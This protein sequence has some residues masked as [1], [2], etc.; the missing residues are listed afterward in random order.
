MAAASTVATPTTSRAS[1]YSPKALCGEWQVI[2]RS[3]SEMD[4]TIGVMHWNTSNS[5]PEA[6]K[7]G[8]ICVCLSFI[9]I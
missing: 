8:Y 7:L 9:M 5:C 1:R 3:W 4:S 2:P 6:H